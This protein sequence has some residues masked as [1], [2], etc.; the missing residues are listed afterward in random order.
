[1]EANNN[2]NAVRRADDQVVDVLQGDEETAYPVQRNFDDL[3]G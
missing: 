1:M 2:E 3:A